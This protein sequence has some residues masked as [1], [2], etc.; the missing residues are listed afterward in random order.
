MKRNDLILIGVFLA[1]GLIM[2][3][4]IYAARSEGSKVLITVDGR[5][6][7][8]LE[9]NKDTVYV[10]E[11]ENGEKNVLEIKDGY[12]DMVEASCPDKI[13]VNHREIHYDNE[14]IT[15]LPNKVVLRIIDGEDSGLDAV[16]Q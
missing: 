11:G 12:V 1:L 10:I 8:T 5:E 14:T 4:I 3:I 16:A 15:C 7:A 13:C 9:L 6:Y 2:L